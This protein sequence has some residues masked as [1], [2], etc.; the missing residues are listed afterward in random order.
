M[1]NDPGFGNL[2][3]P[4][5]P[6]NLYVWS[7]SEERQ[8]LTMVACRR[9]GWEVTMK[10]GL[11]TQET[12]RKQEKWI[13]IHIKRWKMWE[14]VY[15]KTRRQRTLDNVVR[16]TNAGISFRKAEGQ[17]GWGASGV[18]GVRSAASGSS[19]HLIADALNGHS[20]WCIH[21]CC[22][23]RKIAQTQR[24]KNTQLDL[25][26]LRTKSKMDQQGWFSL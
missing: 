8:S 2:E 13:A 1:G 25:G 21:Y 22:H 3:S 24:F 11:L 5:T 19:S 17:K 7:C 15:H 26:F 9:K 14:E 16:I 20:A 18:A 12:Q 23:F 4:V 10:Y 6:K